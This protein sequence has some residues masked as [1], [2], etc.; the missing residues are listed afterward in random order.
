MQRA[1]NENLPADKRSDALHIWPARTPPVPTR[2]PNCLPISPLCKDGKTLVQYR[3]P[4]DPKDFDKAMQSTTEGME[5]VSKA[6]SLDPG[7][8][9]AWSAKTALLREMSKLA[10]MQGDAAKKNDYSNKRMKR[11]RRPR[12]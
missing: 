11:S 8:E 6:I 1:N 10:E 4:Q 12:G 3:K 9:T 2:S 5:F 7:N